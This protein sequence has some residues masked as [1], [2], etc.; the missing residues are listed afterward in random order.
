MNI[1]VYDNFKKA[2]N[3]TKQ[4]TGGQSIS[5]RL[6]D[7]C[8][9][10]NPVFRLKSND[11]NINYVKWDNNYYN[12]DDVEFLAN[13][14]IA[15]HCSRDAMA[16][17]KGDIG[18]SKQY[19]VRSASA[20]NSLLTDLKFPAYVTPATQTLVANSLQNDLDTDRGTVVIGIVNDTT[21]AGVTYYALDAHGT[22]FKQILEY[23]FS[24]TWLDSAV[25]GISKEI[26]K[27]LIN[28][29][30]YVTSI[31]WFPISVSNLSTFT[32]VDVKV[33]WWNT[34]ISATALTEGG[35]VYSDIYER[36]TLSRHPKANTDGLYLNSAPFTKYTLHCW[37]FGDI[38]I[39]SAPFVTNEHIRLQILVDMVTGIADIYVED[40][41]GMIV[42]KQSAQFGVPMQLSQVSRN[43]LNAT[44]NV[45]SAV[46]GAITDYTSKNFVRGTVG[47]ANGVVSAVQNSMP[48][49]RTLGAVGSRM[50]FEVKPS[51]SCEYYYQTEKDIQ[52]M[53]RPLMEVRTISSL[54]GY[55]ECENVDLITSATPSEKNSI[56]GMM[57]SGFFYE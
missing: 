22:T 40:D 32:D 26:Q 5:V 36:L 10:V 11:K 52:T 35:K 38:P 24:D 34:G 51:I 50:S 3:S 43:Y 46:G 4:P 39:D 56:I 14:E 29:I 41:G 37:T 48:Q 49:L 28:P 2:V 7:N 20:W 33:G 30:Q 12:V 6:K 47:I 42:A 54:S 31:M 1:T 9:V 16:T 55:I 19:V 23:M 53:G 18:S 27:E 17:F 45:V 8:S 44:A 13:E 15:L 57:Q 21:N 25:V